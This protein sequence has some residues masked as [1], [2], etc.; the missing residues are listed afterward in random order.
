MGRDKQVQAGDRQ[1]LIRGQ[2]NLPKGAEPSG[3]IVF[4][5]V[6]L[7]RSQGHKPEEWEAQ[8]LLSKMVC[9]FR[10]F[11]MQALHQC[12]DKKFKIY[13]NFPPNTDFKHPAQVPPDAVW[14]SMHLGNKPCIGGHVIHNTFYVVFLDGDHRFWVAER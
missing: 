6:H 10:D 2:A 1:S 7:D 12:L 5:F 4:S 13:R 11:G 9:R 14:A 8:G 3:H